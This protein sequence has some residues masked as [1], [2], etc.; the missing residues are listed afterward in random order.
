[1]I[2]GRESSVRGLIGSTSFIAI[3]AICQNLTCQSNL[4]GIVGSLRHSDEIFSQQLAA[5]RARPRDQTGIMMRPSRFLTK[6]GSP[7][8]CSRVSHL[9]LGLCGMP[10]FDASMHSRHSQTSHA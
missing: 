10:S 8:L 3:G 5:Y 7:W 2:L 4:I 9:K 6:N 1:M